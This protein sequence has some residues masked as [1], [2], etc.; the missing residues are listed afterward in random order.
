M[1]PTPHALR[2]AAEGGTRPVSSPER[3]HGVHAIEAYVGGLG[4][5]AY[6]VGGVVRDELL[7]S[8]AKDADFLVAGVDSEQLR[9]RLA[10]LG[11]VEPLTVAGRLVGVRFY[12]RERRV[13]ALAPAGI[14]LAPL[15]RERSTGPGRHDFEIVVDPAASIADDLARRDFTVNAIARRVGEQ[16]LVDPFGGRRDLEQRILRAVGPRSLSEDPL[17]I[18]R[19]LRFVSQLALEPEPGTLAAMAEHAPAVALV[20]GERIGGGISAEALGELSKLLLGAQPARALALARDTGVL[21]VIV[22]AFAAAVGVRRPS[23]GLTLDTHTFTVVQL[24]ADAGSSLQVRLAALFHDLGKPQQLA[25]AA[26][27]AGEPVADDHAEL[28]AQLA[29]E[30][31]VRLR[32]PSELRQSVVELVRF[33]T[34]EPGAG[35]G[36][37]ARQLLARHGDEL[38]GALFDLRAA[39]LGAKGGAGAEALARLASFRRRVEQERGSPHRLA[40]LAVDGSDLLALGYRPGRPLGQTLARLLAEVVEEPARNRRELLLERARELREP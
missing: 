10:P 32:Y 24:A 25:R 4:L 7:G 21:E 14:E 2:S 31:L 9:A 8:E 26:A 19:G 11:R 6:V 5:D 33:H 40:D 39:D 15:R 16:T 3:L 20:S 27:A 13:R 12:P 17:R 1:R 29:A 30:T 23:D 37:A 28:G 36:V 38:V 35:N 22:P 18:L 34:L